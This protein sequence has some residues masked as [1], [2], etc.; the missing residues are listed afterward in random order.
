MAV[1]YDLEIEQIA[2]LAGGCVHLAAL[3]VN[4]DGQLVLAPNITETTISPPR[5]PRVFKSKL[6]APGSDGLMQ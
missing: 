3:A 5:S 2:I 6:P 4:R 1:A